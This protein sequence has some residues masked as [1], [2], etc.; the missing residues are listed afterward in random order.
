MAL[1][2]SFSVLFASIENQGGAVGTGV[3]A[4][5]IICQRPAWR[6]KMCI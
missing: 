3:A 2:Y 4:P 5:A 1:I 6:R